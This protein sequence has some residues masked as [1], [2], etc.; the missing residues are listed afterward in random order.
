[1][2]SRVAILV[3][4]ILTSSVWEIQFFSTFFKTSIWWCYC[5]F[6]SYCFCLS[7]SFLVHSGISSYLTFS[8]IAND[9]EY[10]PC[11]YSSSVY[12][13]SAVSMIFVHLL[14][15][16]F[17]FFFYCWILRVL[18]NSRTDPFLIC[19][20]WIFFPPFYSLSFLFFYNQASCRAGFSF[21]RSNLSLFI[22]C[23]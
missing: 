10:F 22:V 8:L 9:V 7:H 2:F 23:A 11:D 16:F 17:F 1:M 12:F 13:F 19:G 14:I 4:I 3:C 21:T 6:L 15:G 18:Y 20:L 5:L